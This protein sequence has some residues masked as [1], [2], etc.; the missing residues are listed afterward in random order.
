[1]GE[2]HSLVL[3]SS[4]AGIH[5]HVISPRGE[6]GARVTAALFSEQCLLSAS[7]RHE[8]L[9]QGWVGS[10]DPE[11]HKFLLFFFFLAFQGRKRQYAYK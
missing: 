2:N 10:G 5:S 3:C 4:L 8:V 11:K 7:V 1:M 9:F 6:G